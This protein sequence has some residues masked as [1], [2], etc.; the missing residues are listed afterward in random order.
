MLSP[1]TKLLI[2]LALG[3]ALSV[4]VMIFS[5]RS[6]Q[7]LSEANQLIA[8]SMETQAVASQVL[9]LISDAETAQRGFLLTERPEYL[10]PYVSALP[11]INPKLQRLKELNA[12][13]AEQRSHVSHL[14]KLTGEKL[15]E[16]EASLALYKEKGPR[17]A[18]ALIETDVGR[19][20][21]DEIRKE[22]AAIQNA[23]RAELIERSSRWNEDV[24]FSRLGMAVLTVFNLMLV[25]TIYFLAR[26]EIIQRERIRR[27]LEEQVRERTAE[28]SELSSN[29]QTV[30]EEERARLAHDLHDEL[31]SILVSSKMDVSWVYNRLKD[32][33]AVLAQR[34]ARAMA[35]LDEGVDVKRR[36]IEDLRPT[37]LDN[38]GLAAAFDWYVN[39]TCQR[40]NLK[41][42]MSIE[43]QD[44]SLSS[45]ISIALFRI[46][47]EALT[48]ILRHAKAANAWIT[49]KQEK[50]GL[51]FVIRDDGL[52][53]ARE[54]EKKRLSHGIL[55]MRQRI[56]SLGGE[57]GI[58]STPGA[59]TTIKIFVPLPVCSASV[60]VPKAQSAA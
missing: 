15:S 2:P 48:N 25:I 19:H 33:D 40:G 46:L 1:I 50:D 23:E 58:E 6:H 52:G 5:E 45:P 26:R 12:E 59:G 18:Q 3:C 14:A 43:P 11:K 27:T 37:V 53:L 30:Q 24:A 8:S 56:T 35:V 29:L 39:H 57:F 7:R 34:L 21:M 38:L 54:A 22:V 16:L 4:S 28:L 9:A 32:K 55:G 44:M 13:N 47:Q 17:Q 31:G 20:T 42:E 51:T 49:L 36:I 41:C 10:E 60:D